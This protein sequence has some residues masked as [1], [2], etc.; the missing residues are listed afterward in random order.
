[1]KGWHWFALWLVSALGVWALPREGFLYPAIWSL[2]WA[3]IGF[4]L[5]RWRRLRSSE[6]QR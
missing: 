2:A 5:R 3:G 4:A 6:A 1:M